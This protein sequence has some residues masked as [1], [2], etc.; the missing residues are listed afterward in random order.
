MGPRLQGLT[1]WCCSNLWRV[2]ALAAALFVLS[3]WTLATQIAVVT[4]TDAMI[5]PSLEYRQ[6]YSAFQEAYPALGNTVAIIVEGPSPE[7]RQRTARALVEALESD[8][9]HFSAVYAPSTLSYFRRNGALLLS[10]DA[11]ADQMDA[12]VAA[13]PLLGPV[14]RAPSLH[15]LL[16][17]LAE[18]QRGAAT[19]DD[20]SRVEALLRDVEA[21]MLAA[22]QN[23]P[24]VLSF[25]NAMLGEGAR[26]FD[27]VITQPIL[28]PKKLQPAK[29][30]IK[31]LR[32]H[33]APIAEGSAGALTISVTG[34]I[35]LNFEE[36]KTVSSGAASAGIL[37]A[38]FVAVVL[39]LGIRSLRAVGAMLLNLVFGLAV[40]GAAALWVFGS[41]NI[42]SVAFAVLFIGLGIDFS[43][44]ILLRA[45]EDTTSS[46]IGR[47]LA[48][49]SGTSGVALAVCAPTTA[50]AF[51]SFTTTGYAGLAQLGAIAAIGVFVAFAT[52]LT[53]LPSLLTLF[54]L[55]ASQA[56]AAKQRP[57]PVSPGA[58]LVITA[59]ALIPGI[60]GA[61]KIGFDAD[62]IALKD[63]SAPSVIAYKRL[64]AREDSSPYAVQ[65]LA[66]SAEHALSIIERAKDLESVGRIVWYGSFVP[67][68]QDDKLD[69]VAETYDLLAADLA[70]AEPP[71]PVDVAASARALT[72]LAEQTRSV[73]IQRFIEASTAQIG[74]QTELQNRLFE[75][76]PDLRETL[77]QQLSTQ[78]VLAGDVPAQI[79]ERYIG[80]DGSYRIELFPAKPIKDSAALDAFVNTVREVYPSAT[81]SPV[82]IIE[83]GR[84][85]QRAMLQ[86]TGIAFI[87]VSVFL[88]VVLRS[89]RQ[90]VF[91]LCPVILAGVFT[92]A[93]ASVLGLSFNFANVIVLPLLLGLGVDAGI[94]YVKRAYEKDDVVIG[95][96]L[97]TGTTARAVFLSALTTVG[98]FG[99]L[100]VSG[101]D[102]TAS[103][104]QLL[105]IALFWLLV[106]TLI[107]LPALLAIAPRRINATR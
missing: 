97:E 6:V 50:L 34:K 33:I 102:G 1:Q 44:H 90:I 19:P 62:P 27:V 42:I 37:S 28:D 26:D 45:R 56:A 89:V 60:Y 63:A 78:G 53:V 107:V 4:D 71:G 54:G 13:Q 94:H 69:L 101:H 57:F 66:K 79:T 105:T 9:Q 75:T 2:L 76:L 65:V 61:T 48:R 29:A 16:E 51:L 14:L 32:S 67:D 58:V 83:S 74:L 25:Q 73:V 18:A 5:D 17:S 100:M 21:V 85:V 41:L 31:S 106:T 11:L 103:M 64:A 10:Y 39:F 52:A 7:L 70:V 38:F 30:A 80:T 84:I 55:K 86:A 36:L 15:G 99:T 59:F 91:V 93:T 98:S 22:L 47:A 92:L 3:V 77:Q 82:Q 68:E 104:G 81:G 12:L 23:E 24:R 72:A 49:A 87:L 88:W 96:D 8:T 35:A 43:I 20:A 95:G 40:T 46:D